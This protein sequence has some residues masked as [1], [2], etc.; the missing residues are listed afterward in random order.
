MSL[1]Y[2]SSTTSLIALAACFGLPFATAA[3]SD[4]ESAE[5]EHSEESSAPSAEKG[6][7]YA[8]DAAHIDAGSRLYRD[9]NCIGCHFRGG[10]GIGP[11]FLDSEWH[12]GG[13]IEQ[14]FSS[15][16][17]GLPDGMPAWGDRLEEEQIWQLAAYVKAFEGDSSIPESP[18]PAV[19]RS[20]EALDAQPR[21]SRKAADEK[22]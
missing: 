22:L 5:H 20:P 21:T 17:D 15:I 16:H 19:E 6:E 10:G 13:Q 11:P 14:I 18:P 8:G 3:Q 2:L 1:R 12:H 7:E 4:D 9:Y